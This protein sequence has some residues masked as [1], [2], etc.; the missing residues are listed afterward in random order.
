MENETLKIHNH[1]I[2]YGQSGRELIQ[3]SDLE[4]N[5]TV[6]YDNDYM[7]PKQKKHGMNVFIN[8]IRKLNK[9]KLYYLLYIF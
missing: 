4:N 9:F 2:E 6:Y 5:V 7:T 3:R 1:I 8:L